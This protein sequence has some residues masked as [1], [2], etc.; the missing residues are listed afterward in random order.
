ML[1][2]RA[3]DWYLGGLTNI[4]LR[5]INQL[6]LEIN[7]NLFFDGK[8]LEMSYEISTGEYF[9]DV[10]EHLEFRLPDYGRAKNSIQCS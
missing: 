7:N 2:L 5:L 1:G 9:D 3:S 6:V 4:Y 8:R 10:K